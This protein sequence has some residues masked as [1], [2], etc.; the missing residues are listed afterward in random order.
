MGPHDAMF[1]VLPSFFLHDAFSPF[2]KYHHEKLSNEV[3]L[4]GLMTFW[5]QREAG[6]LP[7]SD[8]LIES[9]S[10]IFGGDAC[11]PHRTG[12]I[13]FVVCLG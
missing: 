8:S 4:V 7:C 11:H 3:L 12:T 9:F 13:F 5:V 1:G 2:K 6:D 10:S